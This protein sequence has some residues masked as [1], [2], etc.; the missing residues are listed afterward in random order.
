VINPPRGERNIIPRWRSFDETRRR[1]ELG[2]LP[3]PTRRNWKPSTANRELRSEDFKKRPIGPIAADLVGSALVVGKSEVALEAAREIDSGRLAVSP[4]ARELAQELLSPSARDRAELRIGDLRRRLAHNP[5]NALRW[6]DLARHYTVTG[7]ALKAERAIRIALELAP[8]NRHVLRCAARLFVHQGKLDR[9][10]ALLAGAA[11][12]R[13]DPW[14]IASEIATAM[15]AGQPPTTV[16]RARALLDSSDFSNFDL[17]EMASA[18]ATLEMDA[19]DA[20]LSRKLFRRSLEEPTE[21]SVAQAAWAARR[22]QLEVDE[23]ALS[24]PSSW[25]ARAIAAQR[26]GKWKGAVAEASRWWEDQPFAS[27]PA[28]FGS[29]EA[30]KGG[31]FEKGFRFAQDG[32]VANAGEFILHNNAAFC[33]L[34]LNRIDEAEY[35][36]GKIDEGELS[37]QERVVLTAT[38]GLFYYRTGRP[39]E[40]RAAYLTAIERAKDVHVRT[41]A[42]IILARE[43]LRLGQ[44]EAERMFARA[45]AQSDEAKVTEL[46]VWFDQLADATA[47]QPGRHRSSASRSQS[48]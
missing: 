1:G 22:V 31:D 33:L 23:E 40:G 36:L 42:R 24:T 20:R 2:P 26:A 18:L 48:R 34:S 16:R 46:E 17:T 12:T 15:A 10:Q 14:L 29:Y 28:V 19:G 21:N 32:L 4:L 47:S 30:S 39:V 13:H 9:A 25:E 38:R 7:K 37:S 41:L 27:G 11:R 35:H 5:R 3:G 43:E 6:T 44:P 8:E 45:K